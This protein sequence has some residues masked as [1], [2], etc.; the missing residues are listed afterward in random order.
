MGWGLVP[1]PR[2]DTATTPPV[3]TGP[4]FETCSRPWC[5]VRASLDGWRASWHRTH[6]RLERLREAGPMARTDDTASACKTVPTKTGTTM[7][8]LWFFRV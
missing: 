7:F 6:F 8:I 2:T 5:T 3:Q 1:S 4:F